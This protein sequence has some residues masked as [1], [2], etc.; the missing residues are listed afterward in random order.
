MANEKKKHISFSAMQTWTSCP[1]KYKLMYLG[2]KE[3]IYSP[4]MD[5]GSAIHDA[6]DVW[7]R[8][9]VDL[10]D[11]FEVRFR[12]YVAKNE[13]HYKE[14]QRDVIDVEL[15]LQQ[16]RNILGKIDK[17]LKKEYKDYVIYDTE[18]DLYEDIDGEEVKFKGF[19]D[20]ILKHKDE[21]KYV[22]LD[23]KTT[24]W[25][26]NRE[27]RSD[28]IKKMQPLLYKNFWCKKHNIDPKNVEVA[29]VLLKRTA[30]RN[31]CERIGIRSTDKYID[32]AVEQLGKFMYGLETGMFIKNR[33]GC[34]NCSFGR[35]AKDDKL[36]DGARQFLKS[37]P[38]TITEKLH[39]KPNNF[40]EQK[41]V[42][43]LDREK[44]LKDIRKLV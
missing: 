25:G 42:Y 24:S 10:L 26:W 38:K 9:S 30:K 33:N 20:V 21:D 1:F 32:R 43:R 34:S 2:D 29:F 23:W 19:I 27:V 15:W 41:K 39:T 35:W 17:F 16:G 7:F 6:I 3:K 44:M 5:F 37:E 31:I 18:E 40:N 8:E 12:R 4:F 22:L 11:E 13:E 28:K 36:C 14:E